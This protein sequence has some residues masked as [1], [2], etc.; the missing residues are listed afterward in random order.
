M[1]YCNQQDI[2]DA[3]G[4]ESLVQATTAPGGTTVD[5]DKVVAAI[6]K[7]DAEI[8]TYFV[9]CA[10][11][12]MSPVPTVVNQCSIKLTV[13]ELLR[14]NNEAE[15]TDGV[16]AWRSDAIEMLTRLEGKCYLLSPVPTAPVADTVTT[17]G[18]R[19]LTRAKIFTD[20]LRD[21]RERLP[22]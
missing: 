8:D 16:K 5:E 3:I 21:T 22:L 19:T 14:K 7:A 17:P 20:D 4:K 18:L 12:P 13:Y 1:P 11:L 2:E 9:T 15:I 6:A 10:A